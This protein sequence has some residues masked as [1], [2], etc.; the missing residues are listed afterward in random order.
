MEEILPN[1]N[2]GRTGKIMS[3]VQSKQNKPIEK[4]LKLRNSKDKLH[5]MRG[6][7]KGVT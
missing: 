1:N 5:W 6:T 4:Q 2:L 3:G 7:S